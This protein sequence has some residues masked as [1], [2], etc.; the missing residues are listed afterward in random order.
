MRK[1]LLLIIV[2]MPASTIFGQ[3]TKGKF[4]LSGGTGLQFTGS[5]VKAVSDG[6]T[7]GESNVNSFSFVPTFGYFVMDNLAV[8]LSSKISTNTEKYQSGDKS[9]SNSFLILPTALYYFPLEGKF[10]PLVQIGVGYS[11]FSNEWVSKTSGISSS[12]ETYSG[13]AFNF[14]GGI[15]YFISENISFNFSLSY[16]KSTLT[17]SDQSTYKYKQGDFGSNIGISVF[18]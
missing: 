9:I 5:N 6:E 8:G 2:L 16:T 4:L 11:S 14:G 18:L 17:N 10:R 3:T 15:S 7:L 13:P 12:K 1:L